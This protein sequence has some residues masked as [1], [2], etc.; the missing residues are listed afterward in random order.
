[1]QISN[2]LKNVDAIIFIG[3]ESF[4]DLAMRL[5][6]SGVKINMINYAYP[7]S[8]ASKYWIPSSYWAYIGRSSINVK[9]LR[10]TGANTVKV[11]FSVE[12]EAEYEVW[13]RIAFST[14]R[15]KLSV[16]IDDL[17]IANLKPEAPI[18]YGFK[19]VKL[20]TLHLEKGK[21]S[22]SLMNDGTGE[23]DIDQI[24]IIPSSVF[25]MKINELVSLLSESNVRIVYLLE[26]ERDLVYSGLG[27]WTRELNA[28]CS[29][30]WSLIFWREENSTEISTSILLPKNGRYMISTRFL[31]GPVGIIKVNVN[32][33]ASFLIDSHSEEWRFSWS[34]FGPLYLSA[35]LQKVVI[36]ATNPVQI[37]NVLL[38]SLSDN[39]GAM[40]P[41]RI[42]Q[43]ENSIMLN[44]EEIKPYEYVVHVRA[45]H[46]P[47]LILSESYHPLWRAYI[48][49]KEI[50]SIVTYSFVNGFFINKTGEFDV[51]IRFTGQKYVIIGGAISLST[52]MSIA[53]YLLFTN[54]KVKWKVKSALTISCIRGGI[55]AKLYTTNPCYRW[56]RFHSN[57]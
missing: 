6:D 46:P 29:G 5:I 4:N 51:V 31:S 45:K 3:N 23:N 14:N 48:N 44:Y 10:T 32:N 42:F 43:T 12:H 56:Y 39:E 50:P 57:H 25:D 21:H 54:K 11:P 28:H 40:P 49:G 52:L 22:I 47:F 53:V 9:T 33:V 35:S 37:D 16:S 13:L 20:G 2:L 7:S 55:N 38:Y 30:G 18:D 8:D 26:A 41:G 1:M 27:N 36:S 19:W 34:S 17:L 15:G 24:A